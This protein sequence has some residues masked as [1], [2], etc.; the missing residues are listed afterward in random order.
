MIYK[1]MYNMYNVYTYIYITYNT[2]YYRP[3]RKRSH[4]VVLSYTKRLAHA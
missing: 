4:S 3:R 2:V 1:G